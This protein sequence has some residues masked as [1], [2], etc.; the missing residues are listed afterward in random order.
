MAGLVDV[1]SEKSDSIELTQYIRGLHVG[2]AGTV[3]VKTVSG[4]IA[5]FTNASG[6]IPIPDR[7]TQ[8]YSTGTSATN[9]VGIV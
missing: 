9:I 8:V 2:T 6:V 1:D 7:I 5:T 3:K 4:T